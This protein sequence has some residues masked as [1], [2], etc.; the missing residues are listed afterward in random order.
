MPLSTSGF[1]TDNIIFVPGEGLLCVWD[2]VTWQWLRLDTRLLAIRP[3]Q[4]TI[5]QIVMDVEQ[6]IIDLQKEAGKRK[7]K[8]PPR[9]RECANAVL[10]SLAGF[11]GGEG[12]IDVRIESPGLEGMTWWVRITDAPV[13]SFFPEDYAPQPQPA[14]EALAFPVYGSVTLQG[15]AELEIPF[16][17][18][19]PAAAFWLLVPARGAMTCEPI[20]AEIPLP[21][22]R[23][24]CGSKGVS[25]HGNSINIDTRGKVTANHSGCTPLS[26]VGSSLYTTLY[27]HLNTS[28]AL[29]V[30]APLPAGRAPAVLEVLDRSRFEIVAASEPH[31]L[32]TWCV[33]RR[34]EDVVHLYHGLEG[35]ESE[36]HHTMPDLLVVAMAGGESDPELRG[37]L[38]RQILGVMR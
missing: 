27:F 37:Q 17:A 26:R 18:E 19:G 31:H 21:L 3:R 10:D 30:C 16:P 12:D 2:V 11:A 23:E 9:I 4:A 24:F 22:V 33:L 29:P 20:P 34:E 35:K 13:E 14:T 7:A 38:L 5:D 28:A 25:A 32:P 8:L 6:S 36:G 15:L 1:G